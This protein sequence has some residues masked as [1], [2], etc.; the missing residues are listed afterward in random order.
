MANATL[1]RCQHRP[2]AADDCAV[3]E[4]NLNGCVSLAVDPNGGFASG[5]GPDLESARANA[6]ARLPSSYWASD[7]PCSS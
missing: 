6:R 2:A 7:G 4:T 5:K 3:V 1:A